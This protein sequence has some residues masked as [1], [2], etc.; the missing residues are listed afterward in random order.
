MVRFVAL[1][2][3]TYSYL[4]DDDINFKKVKGT[5]K[6]VTEKLIKHIFY[7]NCL[8][9]DK[10]VLQLQ[11][12]FKS[13]SYNTYTIEINK[14]ALSSNN[15]KRLQTFDRITSYLYGASL[16]KACKPELLVYLSVNY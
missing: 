11:Q 12:R 6:C 7:L 14:I 16:G 1:R 9:S 10:S 8:F 5:K 4:T 2:L 13:E 15:D 3:K